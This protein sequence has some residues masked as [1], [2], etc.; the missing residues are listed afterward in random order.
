ME[1][2]GPHMATAFREFALLAAH[3]RPADSA[4]QVIGDSR[5]GLAKSALGPLWIENLT[6]NGGATLDEK[7]HTQSSWRSLARVAGVDAEIATA[8]ASRRQKGDRSYRRSAT[9]P[10]NPLAASRDAPRTQR[11][12]GFTVARLTNA[13]P[14]R[15]GSSDPQRKRSVQSAQR[16]KSA[17]RGKSTHCCGSPRCIA[18]ITGP[19][20]P[21]AVPK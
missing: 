3:K 20:K 15:I 11:N 9:R 2:I 18:R 17:A 4:V 6:A 7:A 10:S 14:R 12:V 19:N 21:L 8:A 1:S 16:R 13:R 5:L